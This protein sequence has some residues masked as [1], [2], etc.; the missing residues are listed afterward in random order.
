MQQ[1]DRAIRYHSVQLWVGRIA[2]DAAVLPDIVLA[3]NLHRLRVGAWFVEY[4][5]PKFAGYP[6]WVKKS[7]LY[8]KH[9]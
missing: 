1:R 6:I 8:L 5:D 2:Y 9:S 7:D 3:I 4:E